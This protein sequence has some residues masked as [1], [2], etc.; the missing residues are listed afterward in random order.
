ML[1]PTVIDLTHHTHD[2]RCLLAAAGPNET[3][4]DYVV[5]VPDGE[6]KRTG[7]T[8]GPAPLL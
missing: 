5:V 1:T 6:P 2:L 4:K 8:V 7:D 3:D